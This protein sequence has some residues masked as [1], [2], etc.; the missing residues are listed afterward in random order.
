MT[1]TFKLQKNT[2]GV[3]I[4]QKCLGISAWVIGDSTNELNTNRGLHIQVRHNRDKDTFKAASELVNL[5]ACAPEMFEL[6]TTI[7]DEFKD[8]GL[9]TADIDRVLK[10]ARG[11]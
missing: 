8:Q 3:D 2:D 6:L 10:K 5:L 11:E 7:R 9:S 4:D 1:H